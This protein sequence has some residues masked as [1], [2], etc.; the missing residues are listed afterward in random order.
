[1]SAPEMEALA[2]EV[3]RLAD[4]IAVAELLPRF[5][6]A[7]DAHDADALALLFDERIVIEYA[8]GAFRSRDEAIEGI[9]RTGFAHAAS[10]HLIATH[11]VT[12]DGD[13]ASAVAYFHAVHL[14][15]AARPEVHADHGGWYL[16]RFV[17]SGDVW[18]I[19]YMKQVSVW[20]A[21]RMAPKAALTARMLDELRDWR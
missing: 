3:R 8:G 5:A 15:D 21:E 11:R 14:D 1:M 10:H 4:H 16:A 9:R 20:Q 13:R 6:A 19:A 12:V 7:Q 17:R 2:A 18:R